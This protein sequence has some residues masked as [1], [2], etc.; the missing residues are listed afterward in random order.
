MPEWN[1]DRK[2][3]TEAFVL[4]T[5]KKNISTRDHHSYLNFQEQIKEC[6]EKNNAQIVIIA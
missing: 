4:G 2:H 1:F 5:D 6:L 3:Y